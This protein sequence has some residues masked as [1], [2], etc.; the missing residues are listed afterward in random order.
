MT[1]LSSQQRIASL[2]VDWRP[3]QRLLARQSSIST[4]MKVAILL[5]SFMQ[6][7]VT[8]GMHSGKRCSQYFRFTNWVGHKVLG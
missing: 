3:L 1:D 2:Q 6:N 7:S 8:G 5:T 4:P